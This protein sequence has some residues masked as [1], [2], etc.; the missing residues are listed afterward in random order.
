MKRL[1]CCATLVLVIGCAAHL[2]ANKCV[3]TGLLTF[4]CPWELR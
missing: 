3:R 2:E 4:T 1:L